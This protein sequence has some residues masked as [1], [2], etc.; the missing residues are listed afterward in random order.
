MEALEHLNGATQVDIIL[1][2]INMPRM[3][4]LTL[5]SRLQEVDRTLKVIVVS[6][7]GDLSNIRTAMNRGAFD[8]I[9]KPIDFDD[10]QVTLEKT[11]RELEAMRR[12]LALQRQYSALQRE[13]E[14]AS[15]I[16][17]SALPTHFPAFPDRTDFDLH[18]AMIPAQEVGGDFYDFF[19]ID[20]THLGFSIGDVSGKG[21]GAAMFMAITH[22]LL[23]ATA[24]QGHGAA[25][26]VRQV[27]RILFPESMPRMFVTLVYGILDTETGLVSYCNAGH[28]LPYVVRRDGQV[29]PLPRTRSIGVCLKGDFDFQEGSYLMTPGDS[30]FLYTDGVT[31]A[32]DAARVQF[33]EHRLEA[34]LQGSAGASPAAVIRDVLHAVT[35]FT[36]G[37]AQSDDITMLAFQYRGQE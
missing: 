8:F 34:A 22:T 23:R 11:R 33:E 27:N 21:M 18:A 5:L 32:I 29:V 3:D 20:D 13:L 35:D 19:L 2:D 17:L 14:V 26:C 9:I 25:A 24:R 37:T 31:E 30:L 15:Q 4:G 10:L 36:D 7:Y 28:N 1:T 6:A 12:G 16:Q